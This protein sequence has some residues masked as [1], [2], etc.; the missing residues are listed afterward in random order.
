MENEKIKCKDTAKE[1]ILLFIIGVLVG[2]VISTAAFLVY[3]KTLGTGS[4]TNDS[5]RQMPGG[6]PPEM[7]SGQNNQ[8]GTPP[9]MPSNEN[10]SNGSTNTSSEKPS[11]NSNSDNN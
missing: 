9:E 3:T 1:K 10:A 2:A 11:S 8:G 7:P 6:T 5:S 4:N